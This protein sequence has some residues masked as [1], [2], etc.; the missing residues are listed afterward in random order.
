[1]NAMKMRLSAL[2]VVMVIATAGVVQAAAMKGAQP[3]GQLA[4]AGTQLSPAQR[5]A[6]VAQIVRRWGTFVL[7]VHKTSIDA[8]V[9]R[10]HQTF[11]AAN[12]TNLQRAVGM[13]T[14]QGMMDALTG[15]RLSDAQVMDS[16]VTQAQVLKSGPGPALLG[17]TTADLVYTPL[18]PCRIADTRVVGGP[19]ASRTSRG[20]DGFT[21]TNFAAQGGNNS[22]DC[23][24][25]ASPSALM[26]N[27]TVVSPTTGGYLTVFP[28]GTTQ[29]FAANL[30]YAS[31]AI[32]GNEIAAKMTIG[33]AT[34]EFSVFA[35]GKTDVVVDVVGYFMAPQA[36][37][38]DCLDVSSTVQVP[39]NHG[40]IVAMV[41]CPVGYSATGGGCNDNA[42][43]E[44][45]G[46]RVIN[47]DTDSWFQC[48]WLNPSATISPADLYAHCCRLPGR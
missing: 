6:I 35:S 5:D 13:R 10:M 42:N 23:G 1:M 18:A 31:G 11:A 41:Q 37:K 39:A 22:S 45:R 44:L 7:D 46:F 38:L 19:I 15:Q 12:D 33:S 26:L 20:F 3:A 40:S 25:P 9:A 24:I 28:F 47:S 27:L 32:V 48:G 29:P 36:T 14:F 17:S 8:W 4:T 43:N 30:N 2:V 34:S 21:A 16:L